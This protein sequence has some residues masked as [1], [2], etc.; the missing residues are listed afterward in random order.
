MRVLKYECAKMSVNFCVR[1]SFARVSQRVSSFFGKTTVK[2]YMLKILSIFTL[3]TI[4]IIQTPD[5]RQS[6]FNVKRL[7]I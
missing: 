1:K 6:I 7:F 2:E 4:I 5:F 3:K